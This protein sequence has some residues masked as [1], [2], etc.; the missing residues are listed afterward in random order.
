M[1]RKRHQTVG[2][3]FKFQLTGFVS[4]KDV[5]VIGPMTPKQ[6]KQLPEDLETFM[7]SA[8]K[9]IVLVSFGSMASS[10][11]DRRSRILS[12][13]FSMLQGYKVNRSKVF[14]TTLSTN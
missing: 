3:T 14:K 5:K 11:D 8:S 9:G 1:L 7:Q 6:H 4:S 13:A 2:K 12:E 10:L